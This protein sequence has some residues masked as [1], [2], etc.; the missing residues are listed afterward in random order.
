VSLFVTS[1]MLRPTGIRLVCTERRSTPVLDVTV[2]VV[3]RF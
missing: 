3:K 2:Q 1:E